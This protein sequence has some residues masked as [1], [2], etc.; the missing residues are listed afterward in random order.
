MGDG[1]WV[2]QFNWEDRSFPTKELLDA[3]IPERPVYLQD[4]DFHNGWFNSKALELLGI[5]KDT[6]VILSP[7]KLECNQSRI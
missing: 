3:V 1:A 4:Q 5:N 2:E 6:Q 7:T